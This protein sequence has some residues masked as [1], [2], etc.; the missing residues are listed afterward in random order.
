MRAVIGAVAACGFLAG[1]GIIADEAGYPGGVAGKIADQTTIEATSQQER[2]ARMMIALS[3]VS[4]VSSDVVQ[5]GAEAANVARLINA[6]YDNMAKLDEAAERCKLGNAT[7]TPGADCQVTV[8]SPT[9]SPYSFES[10]SLAG[11]RALY[12]LTEDVASNTGLGDAVRSIIKRNPN[13]LLQLGRTLKRNFGAVR[14][15]FAAYR[16]AVVIVGDSMSRSCDPGSANCQTIEKVLK[17]LSGLE[18]T[19]FADQD[20]DRVIGIM[21]RASKTLARTGEEWKFTAAHYN[22]LV[23][24]IDEACHRLVLEQAGDNQTDRVNCGTA[25]QLAPTASTARQ[26]FLNAISDPLPTPVVQ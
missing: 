15:Y 13:G 10:L 1:C 17:R 16:D 4:A 8:T 6:T 3:V 26:D 21:G 20:A 22:A 18:F 12:K 7:G 5:S 11:Q 2:V 19:S 23:Y 25:S 14:R 24:Q 9:A